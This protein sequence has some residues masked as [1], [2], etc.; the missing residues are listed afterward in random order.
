MSKIDQKRV[1]PEIS[2]RRRQSSNEETGAMD[3]RETPFGASY[4]AALTDL[5]DNKCGETASRCVE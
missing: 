5:W 4:R 3:Y 2:F 1:A